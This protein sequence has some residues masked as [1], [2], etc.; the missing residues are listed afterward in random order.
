M[1]KIAKMI[2]A[3]VTNDPGVPKLSLVKIKETMI[4]ESY[5]NMTLRGYNIGVYTGATKW[6]ANSLTNDRVIELAIQDVKAAVIEQ[7]FGEFRAPL[8]EM[9]ASIYDNDLEK[10]RTQIF[11]LEHQMFIE[12]IK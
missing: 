6:I 10:L 11:A 9:R 2:T 4:P 12:G 8:A 5:S 1:S 7:I 3:G